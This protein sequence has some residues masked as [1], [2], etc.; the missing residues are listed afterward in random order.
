MGLLINSYALS[1]YD[2]DVKIGFDEEKIIG[3]KF[4]VNGNKLAFKLP[5]P[6]VLLQVLPQALVLLRLVL[7]VQV[8][9]VPHH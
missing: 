2:A 5:A 6:R 4:I 3:A 7:Q 9:V 8:L 1:N